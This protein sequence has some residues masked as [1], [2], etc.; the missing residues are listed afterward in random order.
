MKKRMSHLLK[1][2]VLISS[3]LTGC[4]KTE[5]SHD[6]SFVS[7]SSE[8][9]SSSLFV[10]VKCDSYRRFDKESVHF[11]LEEERETGVRFSTYDSFSSYI[12][13]M[14]EKKAYYSN[15]ALTYYES[16]NP[17]VFIENDI[18]ISGEIYFGSTAFDYNYVKMFIKKDKLILDFY[19]YSD[20]VGWDMVYYAAHLFYINKTATFDSV[21]TQI[22]Y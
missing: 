14:K 19:V 20:G 21:L 2:S 8:E 15:K 17:D 11:L 3:I 4:S 5:S 7:S 6:D 16:I 18:V 22:R 12:E 13:K 10:D 1:L 9:T